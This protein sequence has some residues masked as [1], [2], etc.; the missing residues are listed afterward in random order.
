MNFALTFPIQKT[1]AMIH[2]VRITVSHFQTHA[3]E[4]LAN[5]YLHVCPSVLL[6]Q[7]IKSKKSKRERERE[8]EK[9]ESLISPGLVPP[10]C[11]VWAPEYTRQ[12]PLSTQS[13]SLR[14][15]WTASPVPRWMLARSAGL[16]ST[17][18]CRA[19]CFNWQQE[20]KRL[21]AVHDIPAFPLCLSLSN[22]PFLICLNQVMGPSD[23]TS[24]PLLRSSSQLWLS[25]F[26]KCISLTHNCLMK[27]FN[28]MR[29]LR[30]TGCP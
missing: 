21:R 30:L 28:E 10:N 22:S 1:S 23:N 9:H 6:K 16:A 4:N 7:S 18:R 27:P 11:H 14:A 17:C 12:P 13:P 2:S 19:A 20:K 25:F 3:F 15:G 24:A 26:S 29:V 5:P 8:A